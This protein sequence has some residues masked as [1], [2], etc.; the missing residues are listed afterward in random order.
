MNKIKVEFNG[1]EYFKF[2]SINGG[3]FIERNIC[4][5]NCSLRGVSFQNEL[6]DFLLELNFNKVMLCSVFINDKLYIENYISEDSLGY[7]ENAEESVVVDF[8]VLDRFIGLKE[9]DIVIAKPIGTLRTFTSS[10]LSELEF[11]SPKYLSKYR[12][13]IVSASD[14]IKSGSDV[15]DKDLKT[16]T[17]SDIVEKRAFDVLGEACQLSNLFLISN[18]YDTLSFERANPY[19]NQETF[20]TSEVRFSI[21][22]NERGQNY[23]NFRKNSGAMG[24]P[25]PF[26]KIILNSGGSGEGKI[27]DENSSIIVNYNKGIPHIQTVRHLSVNATLKE[28]VDAQDFYFAGVTA[29]TNSF[30][31]TIPNIFTDLDDNFFIPNQP[32]FVQDEK[33]GIQEVMTLLSANFTIDA[34]NGSNITLVVTTQEAFENNASIKQKKSL[35]KK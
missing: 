9:S 4:L 16:F 34:K 23:S 35:M 14:L 30:V 5:K 13:K 29:M 1:K 11:D 22:R 6:K 32:I 10:I 15:V 8:V 25:N 21:Y 26:K 17:R 31:Y 33:Y 19:F 28:I 24:K 20:Q 3:I 12:R 2:T 27:A 18:G 7:S